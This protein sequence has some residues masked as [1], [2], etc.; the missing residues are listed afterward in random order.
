[1]GDRG[2]CV[3]ALQLYSQRTKCPLLH[4]IVAAAMEAKRFELLPVKVRCCR[5]LVRILANKSVSRDHNDT[6]MTSRPSQSTNHLV[7]FL[8]LTV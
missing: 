7:F 5:N 8:T 1:M 3:P 2:S 4:F 6:F